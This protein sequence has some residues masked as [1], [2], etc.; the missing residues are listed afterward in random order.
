MQWVIIPMYLS[1][2]IEDKIKGGQKIYFG[3]GDDQ[4]SNIVKQIARRREEVQF[5]KQNA[6]S[7][8]GS[9]IREKVYGQAMR[10]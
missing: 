5:Q 10:Q 6:T 4:S 7:T 3:M 8:V 1:I 2:P 9:A